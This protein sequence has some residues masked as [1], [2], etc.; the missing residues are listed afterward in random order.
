MPLAELA[1]RLAK[2]ADQ[3]DFISSKPCSKA[4]DERQPTTARA[5]QK[6][7]LPRKI[8]SFLEIYTMHLLTHT[9]IP[10]LTTTHLTKN[11]AISRACSSFLMSLHVLL[12]R[13]NGTGM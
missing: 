5:S 7:P 12:T 8:V 3:D 1:E 11:F 4:S 13:S 10:V 6:E 2:L 9:G